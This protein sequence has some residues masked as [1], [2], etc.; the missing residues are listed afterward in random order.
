MLTCENFTLS[1][2]NI[3]FVLNKEC[4]T[5]CSHYVTFIWNDM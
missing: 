4:I 2:S 1:V 5:Y 3:S